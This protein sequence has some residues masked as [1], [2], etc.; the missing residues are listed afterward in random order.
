M[1]TKFK[2]LHE[3]IIDVLT[4]NNNEF[5]TFEEIADEIKSKDLWKRPS[6][7]E[8]PPS[9]QIRLRTIVQKRYKNFFEFQE[10]DRIRII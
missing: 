7:G 6:D 2:T 3:A 1:E 5:M 4:E 8:Y 10:P 9:Y